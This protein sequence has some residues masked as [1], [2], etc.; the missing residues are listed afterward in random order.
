MKETRRERLHAATR[1]E[2]KQVARRQI[3]Q[4]GAPSLSLRSIAREMGLTPPA[5]YRYF[6]N[7]DD[8]VTA[9]IVDAYNS[10]ADSLT[11]AAEE[12]PPHH[13][14]ERFLAFALAYRA[15]AVS[16]P[17]DYALVFG[18]PIPG[19]Q[20]PVEIIVPVASRSM[21]L[22]LALLETAHQAG[23]LK[24]PAIYAY[25]PPVLDSLLQSW[26][27]RYGVTP[28]TPVL[29]VA[30][31]GWGQLHGLVTLEL[32][33]HLQPMVSDPEQL[34]RYETLALCQRLGLNFIS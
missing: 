10:L 34:Y 21:A 9:L 28:P 12:H 13:Y 30:L 18:T 25:L 8:L 6:N 16:H 17:Q 14:A 26:Q 29:Y 33:H 2:I 20:G 4:E 15:W 32:F 31:A 24:L 7:R 3:A 11:T 1:E 27:Q 22:L 23:Q 19:Y 5:L